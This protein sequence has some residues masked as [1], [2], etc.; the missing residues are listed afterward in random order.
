MQ[1]LNFSFIEKF[2]PLLHRLAF[3]AEQLF[4]TDPNT[5]LLKARQFG[6]A[7]AQQVAARSRYP[8]SPGERQIDLLNRL[9]TDGLLPKSIADM[10]HFIRKMG[11]EANHGLT[12]NASDALTC[13]RFMQ[14]IAIWHVRAHHAAAQVISVAFIPPRLPIDQTPELQ[15]QIDTLMAQLSAAERARAAEESRFEQTDEMRQKL[16]A[17]AGEL[18]AEREA[19]RIEIE[20]LKSN[21]QKPQSLSDAQ[22]AQNAYQAF[23]TVRLTEAD[24]RDLIDSALQD[25]GWEAHHRTLR[26][27]NGTAPEPGKNIAIAE[28]KTRS[29]PVDYALFS[30]ETCV[31]VIEAKRESK[32]VPGVLAQA[33]RYARDIVLAAGASVKH[34]PFPGAPTQDQD[35]FTATFKV[36][37]AFATNGRP[38]VKQMREKSGIWFRDLRLPNNHA[39]DLQDWFSPSDLLSKLEQDQSISRKGVAEEPFDYVNLREYQQDAIIAIERAIARGADTALVSMATG[40][41]KTRMAI[42]LMYRALKHKR[43]RRILFLVDRNA[44]ADQTLD[45]LENTELENLLKFTDTYGVARPA[46]KVLGKETRVHVAT[47]QSM[48]ARVLGGGEDRPTPG[49]YDLIIVD[50]AHRG[51]S[52]DAELR[53]EDIEFRSTEDYLSKYRRVLDYFDAVKV[54]LTATPALQTTEIFGAPVYR[55]SYRQAVIDG[56]LIDHLPPKRIVT[57][58]NQAGI[59]FKGG[60]EVSI[61]DPDTGEIDTAELPDALNFEVEQFNKRVYT[62]EFNRVVAEAIAQEIPPTAS[63]KTLIFAARDDHA[64]TLVSSL[65]IALAHEY[66]DLPDDMVTKITG[67]VDRPRD[68]I[69]RFRSDARPK[70]VVTVDMLTT[71]ID[72]PSISNLVFVRRV[73]SRILYDQMIGR[74]TRLCPDIGKTE[75]RIFDAVDLY[76]NLQSMTDMRPVVTNPN[77]SFT[78]LIAD[79]INAPGEESRRLVQEQI[80]AKLRRRLPRL[81]NAQAE[82]IEIITGNRADDLADHLRSLPPADCAAFLQ[83]HPRLAATLDEPPARGRRPGVPIYEGEDELIAIEDIFN[84]SLT[85]EDYIES[86]ERFI[87][88]NMN[89]VAGMVAATQ[90]PRELTRASLRQL[91]LALDEKQFSEAYLRRAYGRARNADI[92]AHIVGFIRQAALGDPLVPYAARVDNAIRAFESA[93]AWTL[94][95]KQWLRRIGRALKEYPVA[96]AET[97]A[98]PAFQQFGGWARGDLAFGGKLGD[99]LADINEAIWSRQSPY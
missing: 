24:T 46:D 42:A 10:L 23:E 9:K 49:T 5:S 63:G 34:A 81:T 30:G 92:A 11:N 58:L 83:A 72:I 45:S 18:E 75:F 29:G 7:V 50:E 82:T 88:E 61:V 86:F 84:D 19:L 4:P 51:Y 47:I 65:K 31:G 90:R 6:E 44:L 62:P 57:A 8:A 1:S 64:D 52:L 71:G 60:E 69:R 80:V 37:F 78:Q 85:P 12:G 67:S 66:G 39:K 87:R 16:A 22:L 48:V 98:A 26:Q 53:D 35:E 54:G 21:S 15:A 17:Q 36:P 93:R 99:V 3:L 77:L 89:S 70:Y 96:D 27:S 55:Y 94:D 41:G 14:T 40:T 32:D 59:T 74:A 43:F 91:A 68:L 33:E 2:E 97:L 20:T 73:N 25:A 28:W 56:Y 79:L 95:Q 13:L 76:D 38:H